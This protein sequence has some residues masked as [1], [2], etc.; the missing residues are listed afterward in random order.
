MP[1][2]MSTK[3]VLSITPAAAL[4]VLL[5]FSASCANQAVNRQA[6]AVVG[7]DYIDVAPLDLRLLLPDAPAND[8]EV[9]RGEVAELLRIQAARTPEQCAK[10]A[11]DVA[12]T[13]KQ[14]A[15]ALGAA[16]GLDLDNLKAFKHLLDRLLVLEGVFISK[17]KNDYHWP[18]PFLLDT[19]I[20]PCITRPTSDAY[21]SGH[22]TWATMVALVLADM[23]PE[24]RTQLLQRADEYANNRIIGGVHYPS[25]VAAGQTA[26][27][28]LVS[29]LLT[30][31]RFRA[32]EAAA[33]TELRAALGLA[34]APAAP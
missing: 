3:P 34:A 21:P 19:R 7:A 12:V 1:T 4:G 27:T 28:I 33:R 8:S 29:A 5:L 11:A 22:S 14:F 31:P 13:P 26:G 10:A 2:I 16:D 17:V 30:S 18:R 25:D 23:I 24:R 6:L 20:Q 32:D 9:T 15:A